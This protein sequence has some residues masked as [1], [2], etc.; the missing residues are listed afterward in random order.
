MSE[1]FTNPNAWW[2]WFWICMIA[3]VVRNCIVWTTRAIT[4][5]YPPEDYRPVEPTEEKQG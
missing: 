1:T 3:I 4:G 5:K 2:V